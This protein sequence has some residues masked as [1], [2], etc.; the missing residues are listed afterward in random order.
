MNQKTKPGFDQNET[1]W[2]NRYE[3]GETGWDIGRASEPLITYIDQLKNKT[4][5]ILIPGGGSSYE[6]FYLAELGFT[7]ITVIDISKVIINK[8]NQRKSN[9]IVKFLQGNF[10]DHD[11]RYDLILEQT[12]FCALNPDLRFDYAKKLNELLKPNGKVAGVLFNVEFADEG[13]P[14]GGNIAEYKNYFEPFFK[15]KTMEPCYNSIEP[16]KG[17]EAFIILHKLG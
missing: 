9:G 6:A 10:F 12:F 13:P 3:K 8:L 17:N 1:F 15:I 16:R 4:I 14:F 2:N 5:D 11:G 7:N